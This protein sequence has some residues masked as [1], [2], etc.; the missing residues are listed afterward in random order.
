M[1]K[2]EQLDLVVKRK[3]L[4]DATTFDRCLIA[5]FFLVGGMLAGWVLIFMV[6]NGLSPHGRWARASAGFRRMTIALQEWWNLLYWV[7]VIGGGA[8][9]LG[10]YI[11]HTMRDPYGTV[12]RTRQRERAVEEQRRRMEQEMQRR[13]GGNAEAMAKPEKADQVNAPTDG[14]D[15]ET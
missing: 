11:F 5:L 14:D 2:G 4:R 1:T 7:F 15:G 13:R 12:Q 8:L 3:N 10:W 9:A 6:S